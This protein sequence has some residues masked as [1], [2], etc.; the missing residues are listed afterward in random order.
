[1]TGELVGDG[2]SDSRRGTPDRLGQV[3]CRNAEGQ[4][5]ARTEVHADVAGG[6]PVILDGLPKAYVRKRHAPAVWLEDASEVALDQ[7]AYLV[8]DL[9]ALPVDRDSPHECV[10][11]YVPI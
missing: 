9:Y 11:P 4:A 6:R 2:C 5:A 8:R 1:M 3:R 7:T 10:C